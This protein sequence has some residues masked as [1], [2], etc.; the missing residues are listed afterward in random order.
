RDA[1]AA[2]EAQSRHPADARRADAVVG[3]QG[4][5]RRDEARRHRPDD[6]PRDR[7]PGRGRARAAR[8][9][10]PCRRRDAGG[11]ETVRGGA[12]ALPVAARDPVA[13]PGDADGDR[14]RQELDDRLPAA[15]GP[16]RAGAE[17][18]AE[19][20]NVVGPGYRTLRAPCFE[21]ASDDEPPTERRMPSPRL[22]KLS[23]PRASNW[24]VRS[25]LNSLLDSATGT[26]AA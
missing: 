13:L 8:E 9:S 21:N 15:D 11:A 12:G 16:D 1:V 25:R 17:R 3:H 6:D 2:R 5:Q 4:R 20:R 22:A 24:L 19:T 26:G 18:A 7:P 14:R 23:P 10:H